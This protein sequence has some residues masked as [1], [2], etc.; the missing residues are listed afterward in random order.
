[1]RTLLPD[2][3]PPDMQAALERRRRLGLDI[4]DETWEGVYHMAPMARFGHGRVQ[5]RVL[6]LLGPLARQA[7]LEISGPFNLGDPDDFRIP[8]LGVHGGR[9]GDDESYLTT[10]VV[11]V[12]IA[13]PEDETWDKVDFYASHG[14]REVFVLDAA[15]KCARILRLDRSSYREAEVSEL[16]AVDVSRLVSALGWV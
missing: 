16:L 7:G 2:V 14:V 5:A 1:M 13:S 6:E 3:P 9:P 4:Y 8:D 11:V 12:E 15:S 10:A